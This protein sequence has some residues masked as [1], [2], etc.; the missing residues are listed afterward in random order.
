[1]NQHD[2]GTRSTNRPEPNV[3]SSPGSTS[4]SGSAAAHS[5]SAAMPA[6]GAYQRRAAASHRA[7]AAF[8]ASFS[9][10]GTSSQIRAAIRLLAHVDRF[11]LDQ[12]RN[13]QV[14][15][16]PTVEVRA[17]TGTEIQPKMIRD[18]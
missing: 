1:V 9:E 16:H 3:R 6:R 12:L 5:S 14:S 13:H 8:A 11:P 2:D 18:M 17:P 7:P 10:K 15:H 4:G